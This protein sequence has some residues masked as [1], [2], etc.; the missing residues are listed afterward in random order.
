MIEYVI[1]VTRPNVKTPFNNNAER[2]SDPDY[3][4]G[5]NTY[6][7]IVVGKTITLEALTAAI[8]KPDSQRLQNFFSGSGIM[9]D[10]TE[11]DDGLTRRVVQVMDEVAWERILLALGTAKH[12][13]YRARIIEWA[14]ANGITTKYSVASD[15]AQSPELEKQRGE[16]AGT[17]L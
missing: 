14:Q 11:S 10:E 8:N 17:E 4:V 6:S 13:T 7:A 2:L 1:E 3:L 16:A 5:L 15:G 9:Y 12:R